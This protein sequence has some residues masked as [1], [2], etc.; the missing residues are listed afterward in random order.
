MEK[1][2]RTEVLR[3]CEAIH[4]AGLEGHLALRF[5][6]LSGLPSLNLFH[7]PF[8]TILGCLGKLVKFDGRVLRELKTLALA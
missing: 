2:V 4:L 5:A 8:E 3:P 7:L 1:F 6:P